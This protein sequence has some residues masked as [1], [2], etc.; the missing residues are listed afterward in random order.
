MGGT[1]RKRLISKIARAKSKKSE[2]VGKPINIQPPQEPQEV[3]GSEVKRVKIPTEV[4]AVSKS[5]ADR[6]EALRK[7]DETYPLIS[8]ATKF[9]KRHLA[10]ARIKYNPKIHQLEYFIVEPQIS[11][12][13]KKIIERT[14]E[15]LHEKLDI[16]F[17][18]LKARSEVYAY[19]NSKIDDIWAQIGLKLSA[20]DAVNAKYYIFRDTV[21][22]DR[23]ESLMQDPNIE[24]I[25]CDGVGLPIFVF[26][27]NPLYGEI[28][29]NIKYG[30][31]NNLDAFVMKLAQKCGRTVSVASPLMDG[32]LA[33]G[34][35]VQITY[36]TDIARKGSNFTIRKFFR[37][38]L[39]PID[40]MNFGTIDAAGLAYLWIAIE[41]ELS[42][43][44]SGTTAT[45]KTTMLNAISLFIPATSKIVSIEDTAELQLTHINWVPQITRAGLG[46]E[47]QGEIDMYTLLKS[48]LRQRPDYLIVG[49]VRGKEASVLFQAM[50]T[51]HPSLA[52]L[53][54]D[55]VET[56][57]H[58]LTTRPIDLPVA[59]LENLDIIVFLDKVK[60]EGKFTRKVGKIIEIEGFDIK[61][62]QLLRNNV[63][64]WSP[65]E[66]KFGS[67]HSSMLSKLAEKLGWSD[68]EIQEELSRRASILNWMKDKGIYKFEDVSK[69]VQMYYADPTQLENM[70]GR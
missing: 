35:R 38:P 23:I 68:G 66:N 25:G 50:A 19:I 59:L 17:S 31:E 69:V 65:S 14:V 12:Y 44:I 40:L 30:S 10:F 11:E 29:T 58:R 3:K 16:D 34:S 13:V 4:A 47:E 18:Q 36:G 52:T 42:L 28:T 5:K 2:K 43:L 15:E 67:G 55:S 9:E 39:T 45:G 37:V 41:K 51:G 24:D 48:A 7:V 61:N 60:K 64:T 53:H 56:V 20:E 6:M 1:N 57:I 54:A 33:D 49:E 70:M 22:L 46:G 63:F 21:G 62:D 27:R 8:T 32:T 26:H